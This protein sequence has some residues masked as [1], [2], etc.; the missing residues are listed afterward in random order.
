MSVEVRRGEGGMA[1]V[2]PWN[3]V[4]INVQYCVQ[5]GVR[6]D[7]RTQYDTQYGNVKACPTRALHEI[8]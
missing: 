1:W 8:P 5:Y 3:A 6:Y 7:A 2:R 4:P